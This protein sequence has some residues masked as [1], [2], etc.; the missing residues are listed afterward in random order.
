M[1]TDHWPPTKPAL[2]QRNICYTSKEACGGFSAAKMKDA[3]STINIGNLSHIDFSSA[4]ASKTPVIFS[5]TNSRRWRIVEYSVPVDYYVRREHWMT[6]TVVTRITW[7]CISRE[8]NQGSQGS[9]G[10]RQGVGSHSVYNH[11]ASSQNFS[12]LLP[13]STSMLLPI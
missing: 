7:E 3:C 10:N 9:Q 2:P 12:L 4:A 13:I 5:G 6:M 1:S 11:L 8:G